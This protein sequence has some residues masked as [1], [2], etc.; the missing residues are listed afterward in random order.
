MLCTAKRQTEID[1]PK[2]HEATEIAESVHDAG[3]FWI[4]RGSVSYANTKCKT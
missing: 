4:E 3:L 2:E 1:N